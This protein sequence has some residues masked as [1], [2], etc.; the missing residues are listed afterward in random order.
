M[1]TPAQAEPVLLF[2][3][4][5]WSSDSDPQPVIKELTDT[6]GP[7]ACEYGPHAFTFTDYYERE[8]GAGLHKS[9][10]VFGN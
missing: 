9:Y 5:M 1:G 6:Y 10:L 3:A 7:V 8:M 4:I 2:V